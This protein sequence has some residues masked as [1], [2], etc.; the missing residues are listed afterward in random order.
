MLLEAPSRT[1][2]SGC[3]ENRRQAV[4]PRGS[5]P[6]GA[7][8]VREGQHVIAFVLVDGVGVG[9][10]D[11]GRNPLARRPT[12]LSHFDDGSGVDLPAGGRLG[13]ADATL[14][15][16]GRP[17]SAT[18][19]TTLLT[20]INAAGRLG[21]HLLGFPNQ[22]LRR[23]LAS[24]N[25]FLDLSERG[26]RGAY[27]N[28]YRCAYLDAL[29]LPHAHPSRPEP[30]LPVKASRI[31]PSASTA[32]LQAAGGPFLTFDHL[33]RGEAL[34][35]DLTNEQP[36]GVGCEVPSRSPV[37]AAEIFLEMGR[38]VDFLMFEYFRTDEAGH[39]RDF[40]LAD[41]ALSDLD[42]FLRAVIRGLREGDGLLVTSDHGNLEDLSI[43]Q[44]TLADV[45][46]LG[47]GRAAAVAPS[48]RSLLDVSPALLDLASAG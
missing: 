36:R 10:R 8:G 11:P 44:H 9:S 43:R 46:V 48:I 35:H 39:L 20:G 4:F 7:V 5:A 23:L 14:G 29:D 16:A 2:P 17:Q 24:Q 26:L 27:A 1:E 33:R 45:P 34:Y 32:A 13:I 21:H 22:A 25:L 28:A 42:E 6:S 40:D 3:E 38:Q 30:P 19:H 15:I 37:E 18:G 41:R 12:L 47:F 31:R